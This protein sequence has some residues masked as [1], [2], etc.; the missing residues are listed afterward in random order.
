MKDENSISINIK[1]KTERAWENGRVDSIVL[2]IYILFF[3]N[4]LTIYSIKSKMAV[5]DILY[6]CMYIC[7]YVYT[8]IIKEPSLCAKKKEKNGG[9][10]PTFLCSTFF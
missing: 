7:I 1:L 8:C 9:T 3:T 5:Q 6:I 10:V 4:R 2:Y